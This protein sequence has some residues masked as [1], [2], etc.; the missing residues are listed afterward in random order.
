MTSK[1]LGAVA[2]QDPFMRYFT[3]AYVGM[4]EAS[5]V[6]YEKYNKLTSG[7]EINN[8]SDYL[9]LS[10]FF[11]SFLEPAVGVNNRFVLLL[12][13]ISKILSPT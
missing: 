5:N 9:E 6:L 4:A 11:Q 2:L 10:K 12:F 7:Q 3:V 13:L 1:Q 8:I